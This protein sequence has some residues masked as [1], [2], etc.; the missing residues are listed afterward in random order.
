MTLSMTHFTVKVFTA[1][2]FS[3]C[4]HCFVFSVCIDFHFYNVEWSL[5]LLVY[6]GLGCFFL[7]VKPYEKS[8]MSTVDGLVLI[9]LGMITILIFVGDSSIYNIILMIVLSTIPTADFLISTSFLN[10]RQNRTLIF[11]I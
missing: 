8:W 4:T 3:Q 6:V 1:H 7:A 9:L 10:K 11:R 5:N 2:H